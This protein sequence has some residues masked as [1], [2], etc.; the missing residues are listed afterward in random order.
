M[1]FY[2]I[3]LKVKGKNL[4]ATFYHRPPLHI[5]SSRVVAMEET[6]VT[7]SESSISLACNAGVFWQARSRASAFWWS[8]RHLGFKLERGLGRDKNVSQGVG[9]RLKGE[10]P[11]PFP[12][13][14]SQ[15][16]MAANLR[17]QAPKRKRLHCRLYRKRWIPLIRYQMSSATEHLLNIKTFRT[18]AAPLLPTTL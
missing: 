10:V 8:E 14:F 11:T 5:S 15:A 7:V 4:I 1:E 13:H 2:V 12:T 18:P 16:N 9:V 6:D 3:N 17:S